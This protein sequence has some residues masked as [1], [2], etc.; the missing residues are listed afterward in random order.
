MD[1]EEHDIRPKYPSYLVQCL[2]LLEYQQA[3]GRFKTFATANFEYFLTCSN[4]N[5]KNFPYSRKVI[6]VPGRLP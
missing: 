4:N 6:D 2:Y 3:E 5:L 1:H